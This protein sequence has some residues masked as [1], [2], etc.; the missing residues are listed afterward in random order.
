MMSPYFNRTVAKTLILKKEKKTIL[1][2]SKAKR[3]LG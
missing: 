2:M 1:C 3:L